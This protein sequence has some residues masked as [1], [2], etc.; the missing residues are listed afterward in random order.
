MILPDCE[1][2]LEMTIEEDWSEVVI[3][4]DGV[5]DVFP[6]QE[7]PMV[8]ESLSFP[9]TAVVVAETAARSHDVCFLLD[10]E[11]PTA[12]EGALGFKWYA[13]QRCFNIGTSFK[14]SPSICHP[15]VR[16]VFL[17][18]LFSTLCVCLQ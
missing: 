8:S 4:S 12:P 6:T 7:M 13:C 3:A 1:E 10:V 9:P 15:H 5:W 11:C 2:V 17:F 14:K 16:A 18:F